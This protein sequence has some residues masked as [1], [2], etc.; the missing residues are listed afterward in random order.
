MPDDHVALM[1]ADHE[2]APGV[3]HDVPRAERILTLEFG[4][5][6][7]FANP[8][9]EYRRLFS[10]LLGTFMLVLVAAGGGLL[11]AKG[12]IS[13][14]AAVVAPG[15]MVM[16]IILFMG[17]VSGAHLNPVVSLAFAV[18]GDF[19]W[20][21]VPGYLVVQLLGATLACLFLLAVFGN[22]EHLG[23]TLP[24]PGYHD[25]QA[26]LMETALTGVLVSVILG[27]AS[28]AQNVG[29][30]GALGVGGCIAL[31]GLWAAPVSGAS[32][33]PARSFGPALVSG[34]WTSYWVY[35]IGPL[36]GAGIAVGCAW[37]LRG[38]GGDPTSIAA[39]SGVLTPRRR[40]AATRRAHEITDELRPHRHDHEDADQGAGPDSS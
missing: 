13:L 29:T 34:Y 18:R 40:A 38:R 28:A 12:Q 14:A 6:D 19:P 30:I 1:A 32:M 37:I 8:S 25:W 31:A 20:R 11:H 17:A 2:Q 21:R 7:D 15:L 23:A 10:E 39:G 36:V 35:V 22:V 16:A 24:G 5:R 9:L 33:N 3:M 27:T 26:L 4:S